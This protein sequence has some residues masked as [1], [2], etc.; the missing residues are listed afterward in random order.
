MFQH[1]GITVLNLSIMTSVLSALI[2]LIALTP[3]VIMGV[4]IISQM[5]YHSPGG[6]SGKE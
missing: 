5:I 4:V 1:V 2:L 6:L 3:E